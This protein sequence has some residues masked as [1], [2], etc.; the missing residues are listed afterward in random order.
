[1]TRYN[2]LLYYELYHLRLAV[3]CL[4][5]YVAFAFEG[6]KSAAWLRATLRMLLL[7]LVLSYRCKCMYYFVYYFRFDITVVLAMLISLLCFFTSVIACVITYVV[8][9][10][11]Y[12]RN[13]LCNYPFEY[14]YKVVMTFVI[15]H[16]MTNELNNVFLL[17][18][19]LFSHI[20]RNVLRMY[21]GQL[22]FNGR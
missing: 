10:V 18:L 17:Y 21:N 20:K 6:N 11:C 1:M 13:C 19:L 5:V 14:F 2:H 4:I 7:S 22:Y 3:F 12:F 9:V 16:V 8:L 15:C